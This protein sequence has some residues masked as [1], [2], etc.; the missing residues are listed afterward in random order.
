MASTCMHLYAGR[1]CLAGAADIFGENLIP[2]QFYLGCIA[3]D[4][5]NV[6]G[7]APKATRWAA[8]LRSA[9]LKEWYRNIRRFV[10][11]KADYPDRSLLLGYAVHCITDIM[12]DER[13]HERVWT[14]MERRALPIM[15]EHSDA[16]WDDCFRFDHDQF[17]A[18]WWTREV[19]PALEAARPAG[20]H[21]ISKELLERGR[22]HVLHRY[23]RSIPEGNPAMVTLDMVSD[24]SSLTAERC[25]ILIGSGRGQGPYST[26][27]ADGP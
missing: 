19:R 13:F 2:A 15:M 18:A 5:V 21:T 26:F 1:T 10:E 27:G 4:S 11:D 22:L 12:W 20:I 25:R 14:Q 23:P 3:P 6:N 7:F 17:S 9:D 8:H 16:G 24:L